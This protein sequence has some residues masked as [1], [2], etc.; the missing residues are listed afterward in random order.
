VCASGCRV[1][2]CMD[3]KAFASHQWIRIECIRAYTARAVMLTP[4]VW[5]EGVNLYH[6]RVRPGVVN[7]VALCLRI[8]CLR[9]H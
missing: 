2:V 9:V 7:G 3:M 8:A 6:L 5:G 4:K 1:W